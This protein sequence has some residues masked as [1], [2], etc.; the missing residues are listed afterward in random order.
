MCVLGHFYMPAFYAQSHKLHNCS[1]PRKLLLMSPTTC[2]CL[3]PFATWTLSFQPWKRKPNRKVCSW[4]F[5]LDFIKWNIHGA[6]H[7]MFISWIGAQL[8]T[9]R[10]CSATLDWFKVINITFF[11]VRS[12]GW[13][14]L[15]ANLST[16]LYASLS[17]CGCYHLA[18]DPWD[19]STGCKIIKYLKL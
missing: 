15:L 14:C 6:W 2:N 11:V 13:K 9:L 7:F 12:N 10:Y 1:C 8:T 18:S 4:N 5:R 16:N 17:F 3:L 19:Q